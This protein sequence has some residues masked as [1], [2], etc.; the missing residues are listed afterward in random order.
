MPITAIGTVG[1]A[2]ASATPR[3]ACAD[4]G[5]LAADRRAGRRSPS[6]SRPAM[7]TSCRC[8]HRRSARGRVVGRERARVPRDESSTRRAQRRHAQ[9]GA[10]RDRGRVRARA[11]SECDATDDR[12]DGVAQQ[13]VVARARRRA[14]GARRAVA[15]ARRARRAGRPSARAPARRRVR[16]IDRHARHRPS[17]ARL[18]RPDRSARVVILGRCLGCAS[19]PPRSTPSS[20]TSTATRDRILDAYEAAEA[21]G[22]DLVVFPE[23]T[24][25]GYPPE[26]LLLR[27]AFVAA[28]RPRRSTSSRRAP[29]D[30]RRSS[31]FPKPGRDLAQR[32][33]G[34]RARPGARRVPQAAAAELRRVRRAALLRAAAR[35]RGPLFDDRRRAGRRLDLRGRVEPDRP[36][37][38]AGR[39]RRRARSST[40]TRR[41]TTRAGS[42]EREAMLAT[43]AADASV[44]IV[45]VNLVGG[46]DE[47]VFDGGSLVFDE[48][49]VLVARAQQFAED[50][51]VVDLDVRPTFRKRLLD[52]RG[53]R[54][55]PLA[56]VAISRSARRRAVAPRIEPPLEPVHEVYEALVLGTRDYVRKNGFTDVLIALSGGID[57]SL[58]AAIAVDA[59]GAEHVVGVL[60]PSRYSSE[61]SVTDADALADEPR[62]SHV[63]RP[64]RARARRV[65]GDARAGVRRADAGRRRG[66]RAGAH[67]RQR[68]DDDLEQV[69]LDGAHHR[70]QERDGDRLRDAVRRHG[71]RLRGDQ[72]RRRRRWCTRSAATATRVP[73]RER[74]PAGRDRQAAVGRA[75]T[76]SEGHRLAARR[77]TCSTRSSRATSKRDLSI[78]ELDRA[79]PSIRELVRRVARMVDRNEY[80]RRQAAPGV[81][82]SPK[83]FGKDRRLPITNRWPG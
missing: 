7:R 48:Q 75:A 24:I 67:P 13:R 57:S 12:D 37:P 80:K 64:D 2:I 23:L 72:G 79:R 71:R 59:L 63:H 68:A 69:R 33:G 81:R 40:S 31:A 56:E 51:L 35:I 58:V 26:D 38:R 8:F 9:R 4:A 18:R 82:V 3:H 25:T 30:A 28:G 61:G 1:A 54:S 36:D 53:V 46:Q 83:A 47:L 77:T 19:P 6:R 60:M 45:Y 39:R 22:C 27:P 65:R 73:G 50:L 44:P 17:V 74:D 52:P 32:G 11:N 16:S 43:R 20:A 78:A 15:R 41:P 29:G 76:R 55:A 14:A 34:V 62:H 70:Q 10:A 42:R 5:E 21:A 66:E 49:G